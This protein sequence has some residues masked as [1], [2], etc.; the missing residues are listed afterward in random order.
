MQLSFL[1]LRC[2]RGDCGFMKECNT[3][4]LCVYEYLCVTGNFHVCS[5]AFMVVSVQ[6]KL[7]GNVSDYIC[8]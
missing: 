4:F 3:E 1:S 7:Y 5:G 8:V 6:L 2:M